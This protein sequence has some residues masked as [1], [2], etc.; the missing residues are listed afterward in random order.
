MYWCYV[1]TRLG[2]ISQEKSIRRAAPPPLHYLGDSCSMLEALVK[3]TPYRPHLNWYDITLIHSG[4]QVQLTIICSFWYQGKGVSSMLTCLLLYTSLTSFVGNGF[5]RPVR[6]NV[7]RLTCLG[8][9]FSF[10]GIR[11]L[12]SP[13]LWKSSR[14]AETSSV[15]LRNESEE[16][17]KMRETGRWGRKE[18][19]RGDARSDRCS[20]HVFK[21]RIPSSLH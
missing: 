18:M 11:T 14:R 6:N 19:Q 4:N 20:V 12:P 2:N 7:T 17:R 1:E 10:R 13:P 9:L 15:K 3:Q 5:L 21:M 16:K 8:C